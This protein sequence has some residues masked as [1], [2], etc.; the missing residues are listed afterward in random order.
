MRVLKKL[1]RIGKTVYSFLKPIGDVPNHLRLLTNRT[2]IE[3]GIHSV[4]VRQLDDITHDTC[5]ES[6]LMITKV[7]NN[8]F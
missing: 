5:Y 8:E 4:I 3:L 2:A 6:G 7:V 1:K